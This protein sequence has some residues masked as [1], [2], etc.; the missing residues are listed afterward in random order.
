MEDTLLKE[1]R[2]LPEDIGDLILEDEELAELEDQESGSGL[3]ED[4]IV[5]EDGD[6]VA[7]EL[8]DE[9]ESDGDMIE[10]ALVANPGEDAVRPAAA[11]PEE[12]GERG[13]AAQSGGEDAGGEDEAAGGDSEAN[14]DSEAAGG[15]TEPAGEEI[16]PEEE[17][18]LSGGAA[19]EPAGEAS[20][21]SGGVPG[22]AQGRQKEQEPQTKTVVG[23]RFR[24]VGKSYYFAVGNL[25]VRRGS[26]V[27]VETSRG[28]DY[29]TSVCDPI[30]IEKKKFR[31]PVKRIVRIAT[32][33]DENRVREMREKEHDAYRICYEKIRRRNLDMKLISAEYAF[34][35]SK[36]LFYFTADERVDFRD[37][38]KDLAGVFHTRIEL[39]QIGVR[40]ETRI[41]G[42]Y[43]ICGRPLCCHT[44]LT[45]FAPVSIKM[46]KEQSLSLN[47]T[48]ISGSCGRLM[49]CLKNEEEVYEELNKN[50]PKPGDEIEGNDGLTGEVI[51][52]DILRQLVRMVA[53]VD[54]QKE[55][56]EY[57]ADQITIL[58]RRKR[59]QAKPKVNRSELRDPKSVRR[60]PVTGAASGA[61]GR[62]AEAGA[63]DIP[64]PGA[65]QEAAAFGSGA[66]EGS[67]APE[68][69]GGPDAGAPSGKGEARPRRD[70]GDSR[71]RP[72]PSGNAGNVGRSERPAGQ[73][74]AAPQSAPGGQSASSG[75]DAPAGQNSRRGRRPNAQAKPRSAPAGEKKDAGEPLPA[76]SAAQHQRHRRNRRR[77]GTGNEQSRQTQ[78]KEGE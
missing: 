55:M 52:V 1:G 45:D 78:S 72:R 20:A 61:R 69:A 21:G 76:D 64:G 17:A 74:A 9:K 6:I 30:E 32:P 7:D 23:V 31:A 5:D 10:E 70:R 63:E 47:P 18:A 66:A 26:H 51:G 12:P 65:A 68:G 33:A 40:D 11:E 14:G 8:I 35:G 75:Q 62:D 29:G 37:L 15:V 46:A 59:G 77:S 13:E 43:G 38:V 24:S 44:Y 39:R 3:V 50:L 56:H 54:D 28:L 27:I 71:R 22:D 19:Q 16:G 25:P 48:K 2:T 67:G 42:G 34:D 49:C 4:V 57:P 41:L 36:L 73:N 58:R 60:A 53:L